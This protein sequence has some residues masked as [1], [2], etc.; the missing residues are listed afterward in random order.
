MDLGIQDR[1]ALVTGAGQGIGR[2]I[3]LTLAQ[4][5]ARV[6]VNDIVEKLAKAV[7]EEIARAGGRAIAVVADVTDEDAVKAMMEQVL[8]EW[9][10]VDI[11]VNNA[12]VPLSALMVAHREPT[13]GGGPPFHRTDR[14]FWD[15]T[16]DVITYGTLYCTRVVVEGMI[17][18]RWGR[19]VN[20]TSDAGRGGVGGLGLYSLAKAGIVGLSKALAQE[21]GPYCITVNCISPGF[22][23]TPS[24]MEFAQGRNMAP[25]HGALGLGRLGQPSDIASGV[26]FLVSERAEWI[27]GQ[28]LRVN[29]GMLMPD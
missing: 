24:A 1:V 23:E 21:I 6:A 28:V 17:E 13:P 11:L 16:M 2:Q 8:K 26:S 29:G 7:A 22:I 20:I 18:R 9:G 4:E 25:F 3:C 27:T 14:S 5:G 12:G 15:L 19:I 10:Q